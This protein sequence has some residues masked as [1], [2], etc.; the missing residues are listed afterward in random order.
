LREDSCELLSKIDDYWDEIGFQ[1]WSGLGMAGVYRRVT[2]RKGALLGEV[3]RYYADDYI[4]WSH[5]GE[6]SAER[7]LREWRG[8]PEVMSH[9]VLLLGNSTWAKTRQ[10]SF[11]WG[12]RGWVEIYSLRLGD[13]P[14]KRF[15]DLAYW[16]FM[17]LDYSKKTKTNKD[18]EVMP[19]YDI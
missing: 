17:A 16:A 9:R 7:I 4:L 1:P 18:T 15:A 13:N 8:I 12:F 2:F 3:A 6:H 14:H 11:L 19:V 5:E 10:K